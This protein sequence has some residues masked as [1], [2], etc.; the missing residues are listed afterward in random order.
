MEKNNEDSISTNQRDKTVNGLI[1]QLNNVAYKLDNDQIRFDNLRNTMAKLVNEKSFN[2]TFY[3]SSNNEIYQNGVKEAFQSLVQ[4]SLKRT[5][6]IDIIKTNMTNAITNSTM[7]DIN[8]YNEKYHIEI[9]KTFNTEDKNLFEQ[10]CLLL[11]EICGISDKRWILLRKELNLNVPSITRIKQIRANT[12]NQFMHKDENGKLTGRIDAKEKINFHLQRVYEKN[13]NIKEFKIKLSADGTNISKNQKLLNFSFSII[14]E[15]EKCMTAFGHYLLGC[16][17][18][19]NEDYDSLKSNVKDSFK[20]IDDL[21]EWKSKDGKTIKI[22]KYMGGDMKFL[23][24]FGGLNAANSNHSCLYCLCG[25]SHH[26]ENNNKQPKMKY[27][28][29]LIS[30]KIP[31][32]TIKKLLK[33]YGHQQP[34]L[35]SSIDFNYYVVDLLHLFLRITDVLFERLLFDLVGKEDAK[36]LTSLD[37]NKT[38]LLQK[39]NESIETNCNVRNAIIVSE[40]KFKFRNFNGLER[41]KIFFNASKIF[42]D[43]STDYEIEEKKTDKCLE[44]IGINR[45][46]KLNFHNEV[47]KLPKLKRI[48]YLWY[49]FFSIY[50]DVKEMRL[51]VEEVQFKTENWLK[52]FLNVYKLVNV[53]PYIHIFSFHLHELIR[54]HGNINLFNQEGLERMNS[55]LTFNYFSS[56]NKKF[57]SHIQL[58]QKQN[59][60]EELSYLLNFDNS[61][62]LRKLRIFELN[63]ERE[64][65]RIKLN[66]FLFSEGI[67]IYFILIYSNKITFLV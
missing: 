11:K 28:Q 6:D 17:F 33:D 60:I 5:T 1:E 22:T 58:L 30:N 12:A 8:K 9:Q 57:N 41:N 45:K 39:I 31:F 20:D 59:R 46:E 27:L 25:S 2:K 48:C 63:K 64:K 49:E 26:F 16:Y 50:W 34:A 21:K 32:R 56:T 43:I 10:K 42:Q 3:V 44:E 18:I 14:N 7:Q 52:S 40:D 23:L 47:E 54:L 67:I 37:L 66:R 35:S 36:A 13:P 4:T 24:L 29:L 55:L 51:T 19:K 38:V 62:P 65:A 15:E 53:T 61:E